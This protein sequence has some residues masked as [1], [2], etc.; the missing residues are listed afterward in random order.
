MAGAVEVGGEGR[1]ASDS[2]GV[3]TQGSDA[4]PAPAQAGEKVGQFQA[5]LTDQKEEVRRRRRTVLNSRAETSLQN[6]QPLPAYPVN[7][8]PTL[9]LA[10][11]G[12]RYWTGGS[13]GSPLVV[14]L[15]KHPRQA[16]G[17]R[18]ITRQPK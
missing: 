8:H 18:R 4:E 2:I 7:A 13:K 9:A 10:Y 3:H 12:Y 1:A 11:I 6:S 17:E 5:G 14:S 16:Q 15:S